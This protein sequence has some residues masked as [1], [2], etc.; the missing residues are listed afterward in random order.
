M[1]VNFAGLF[2]AFETM[3]VL[4][5][6]AKRFTAPSEASSPPPPSPAAMQSL[7][8]QLEA[9]LTNV[10]V[11][12]LKEAFNRD[13]ARLELERAQLEEERRRAEQALRQE[14]RRQ[15]A[16][17]ELGRLRL[18][19]VVSLAGWIASIGVFAAGIAGAS[20]FARVL[21]AIGWMLL[22]GALGM[23]FTAQ[24]QVGSVAPEGDRAVTTTAAQASLWLLIAGL[25]ASAFSLLL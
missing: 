6:A 8:G 23:A 1:P 10:V 18:L 24:G 17:R 21:L 4:R 3:M 7:A 14:L 22:L 16:D 20:V 13:H 11:A 2:R 15:A 9:P 19:A 12:A 5:E 25:A